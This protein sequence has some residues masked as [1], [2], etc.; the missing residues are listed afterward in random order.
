MRFGITL[1]AD[2]GR[3]KHYDSIL[4]DR[5]RPLFQGRVLKAGEETWLIWKQLEHKGRQRRYTFQQPDLVIASLAIE[6]DMCVVTR[7]SD[8]FREAGASHHNPWLNLPE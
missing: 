3:K 8:P 7:D 4:N 1:L 5:I 2:E 6:H